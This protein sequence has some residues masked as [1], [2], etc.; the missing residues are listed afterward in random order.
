MSAVR[1]R[2]ET[3]YVTARAQHAE[4]LT[5]L[6][7]PADAV[8][9]LEQLVRLY[10]LDE[11]LVGRLMTALYHSGRQ[12]D[13]LAAYAAA[14]SQ[15]ADELGVDPGPSLRAV[16]TAVLRQEVEPLP[17]PEPATPQ[18]RGRRAD[19]AAR[20]PAA[21]ALKPLER[22]RS[23]GSE[24]FGREAEL[25]RAFELLADPDVRVVTLVG[26]GG[27]GK[28]RMALAI[29]EQ[30]AR[31]AR[32]PPSYRSRRSRTR[33]SCWPRSSRCSG[34]SRSGPGRTWST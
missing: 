28:T 18:E 19:D 2:L 20:T 8:A 7:R 5:R 22:L 9:E 30:V 21:A 34:S 14:T 25:E 13:A 32:A 10:P 17:A 15:L 23:P 29:A 1:T 12:A 24:L 6:G 3:R 31:D 16:Q 11:A 27:I 26:P 4:A 33:T